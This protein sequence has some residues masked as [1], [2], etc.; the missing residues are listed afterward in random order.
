MQDHSVMLMKLERKSWEKF[1]RMHENPWKGKNE[2][3]DIYDLLNKGSLILDAGSGT[4]KSSLSYE[5]DFKIILLDF[6]MNSLR[7]S[8]LATEKIL[9]DVTELPFKDDT[10]DAV[11]AFHILDHI[12]MD[13]RKIAIQELFRVLKK[14]G[15]IFALSFST[16]DFRYGKGN[17]IEKNTFL[18]GNGIFTHYFEEEEFLNL[19]NN[20]KIIKFEKR[21]IKRLI[22]KKSYNMVNLFTV[23]IKI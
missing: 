22:L 12:L 2:I 21:L 19:F 15:Y 10:F 5:K 23:G 9:G 16:E 1:Y 3:P 8:S 18:R 17:E 6:S 20:F 11:I 7:N 13:K 4:G 14:K